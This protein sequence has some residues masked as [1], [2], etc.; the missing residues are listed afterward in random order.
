MV[1]TPP[2]RFKK[3]IWIKNNKNHCVISKS[4]FVK[5]VLLRDSMKDKITCGRRVLVTR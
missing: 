1:L 5:S 2:S 3:I 4:S